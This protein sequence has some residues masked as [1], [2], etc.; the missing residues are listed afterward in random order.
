MIKYYFERLKS[1]IGLSI[2]LAKANF[3]LRNEG[4][5]LGLLWYL[6]EPL[7]LFLILIN[8][9]GF[10]GEGVDNYGLYLLLGL[11]MY[12]FF[13]GLSLK[14]TNLIASNATLV[15]SVKIRYES[16]IISGVFESIYSHAFEIVLFIGFM[17][18]FKVQ[19]IWIL[20]YPLIFVFYILFTT[21]VSF[22]L[23]TVGVFINDLTNVWKVVSK[24]LFFATPIFYFVEKGSLIYKFNILNPLY[25]FITVSRELII[26]GRVPE[27][28][29]IGTLIIISLSTFFIGILLFNKYKDRFA[30]MV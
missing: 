30:E 27:L 21:G 26:Y 7:L 5:F 16:L 13:S 24:L 8:L 19:L 3:K 9:R 15:K 6:L 25:Y 28:W 18:Y 29:M 10:F 23:A 20:T 22:I 4:S 14:S 12:S 17:I 2:Q 1:I 11:I